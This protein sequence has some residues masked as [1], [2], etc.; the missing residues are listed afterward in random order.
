MGPEELRKCEPMLNFF[1]RSLLIPMLKDPVK[2]ISR[3]Y[4]FDPKDVQIPSVQPNL[5]AI[6]EFLEMMVAGDVDGNKDM[7]Q[8]I[9]HNAAKVVRRKLLKYVKDQ[10]DIV[11]ELEVEMLSDTIL[12]HYSREKDTIHLA[13]TDLLCFSNILKANMAR[14]RLK[15]NDALEA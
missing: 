13:T 1:F 8:K 5:E 3:E 12:S 11:D 6:A 15:E 14:L 7:S 10:G 9:L 4:F 2:Y